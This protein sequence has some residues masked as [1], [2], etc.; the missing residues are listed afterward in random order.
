MVLIVRRHKIVFSTERTLNVVWL[1]IRLKLK[2]ID[3]S[4]AAKRQ[5]RMRDLPAEVL[6]CLGEGHNVLLEDALLNMLSEIV[7]RGLQKKICLS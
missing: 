7:K 3:G 2:P 1:L 6:V 5:G 4:V